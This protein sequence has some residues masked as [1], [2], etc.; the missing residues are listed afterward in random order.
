MARGRQLRASL[1]HQLDHALL[2]VLVFFAGAIFQRTHDHHH[3]DT[4]R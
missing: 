3:R 1:T 2:G 4:R